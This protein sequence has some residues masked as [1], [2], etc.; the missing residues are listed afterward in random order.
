MGHRPHVYVIR[1]EW[2]PGG[3]SPN[4]HVPEI[5]VEVRVF[6]PAA[7]PREQVVTAFL[8]ATGDAAVKLTEVLDG[9]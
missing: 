2:A 5:T 6:W 4:A 8:A 3:E 9:A 1:R 7:A